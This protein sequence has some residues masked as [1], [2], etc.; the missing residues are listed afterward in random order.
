MDYKA[1][2]L[3]SK[4]SLNVLCTPVELKIEKSINPDY[5]KENKVYNAIWDTG[6]TNTVISKELA[7]KLKLTPNGVAKCNTAGGLIEAKKYIISLK[8][9]NQ[10]EILDIH[11]TEGTL[12][13]ADFLIG[14]DV[15]TLGDFAIS[16]VD[17]KTTFS[18]RIPSCERV[19]F[20]KESNK[21]QL[22]NM[23]NALNKQTKDL[24]RNGNNK[25]ACGSGKKYRYCHGKSQIEELKKN[26]EQ[27]EKELERIG[28]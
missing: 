17:G 26:I 14:M 27:V 7:Q 16:N 19:D 11:V 2:T 3:D 4:L 6:A 23:K 21:L 5:K 28:A 20:V 13:G 9:P 10:V 8:L 22:A 12:S 1:F 24:Q 25:C 18:F 15:I